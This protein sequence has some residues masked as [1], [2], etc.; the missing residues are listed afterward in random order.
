MAYHPGSALS[1]SLPLSSARPMTPQQLLGIMD[2]LGHHIPLSQK[3]CRERGGGEREGEEKEVQ[4]V[5]RCSDVQG[6]DKVLQMS[7]QQST[8]IVSEGE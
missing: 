1:L 7:R 4:I 5:I 2:G 8:L 6:T 3:S